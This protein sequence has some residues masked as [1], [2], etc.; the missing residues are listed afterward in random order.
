[1]SV[2]GRHRQGHGPLKAVH[3]PLLSFQTPVPVGK[4]QRGARDV[5]V[6]HCSS[7]F[8]EIGSLTKHGSWAGSQQISEVLLPCPPQNTGFIGKCITVPGFVCGCW[9]SKSCLPAYIQWIISQVS[10][11]F[12]YLTPDSVLGNTQRSACFLGQHF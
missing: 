8:F 9:E 6:Y 4:G 10:P 3:S 2:E 1:M 11:I 12:L 5:L 7:C